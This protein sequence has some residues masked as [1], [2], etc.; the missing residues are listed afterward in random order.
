MTSASTKLARPIR[1]FEKNHSDHDHFLFAGTFSLQEVE[2]ADKTVRAADNNGKLHAALQA[3]AKQAERMMVANQGLAFENGSLRNDVDL[4][5]AS[6]VIFG[7]GE[8]SLPIKNTHTH[9]HTYDTRWGVHGGN[10]HMWTLPICTPYTM[11]TKT[12]PSRRPRVT[13]YSKAAPLSQ[14]CPYAPLHPCP[15]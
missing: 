13:R 15:C 11:K 10:E 14:R 3:K 9:L 4:A 12:N 5:K 2:L 7:Q 8:T 6:E 1:R